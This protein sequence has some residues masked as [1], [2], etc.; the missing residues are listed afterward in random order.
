[1]YMINTKQAE[2]RVESFTE[3]RTTLDYAR[4]C[5]S[6]VTG[7]VD[8]PKTPND[9]DHP[10]MG[11]DLETVRAYS[12]GDV[13][14]KQVRTFEKEVMEEV[15]EKFSTLSVNTPV[16]VTKGGADKK[17]I[18]GF[19]VFAKEPFQGTGKILYVYDVLTHRNCNVRSSSVKARLPRPGERDVLQSTYQSC[20]DL[21]PH[22]KAGVGVRHKIDGRK[23]WVIDDASLDP[24]LE[25][26][27]FYTVNVGWEGTR[28]TNHLPVE[29][30][31]I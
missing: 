3:R 10:F 21:A 17:G 1:M 14:K 25:G 2:Q 29:L 28:S 31:I 5:Y 7:H 23:G 12:N 22:F 18:E 8:I 19:I 20:E 15:K 9:S 24:N 13:V 16:K 26:S 4:K 27:G 11:Y 6:V 30:E